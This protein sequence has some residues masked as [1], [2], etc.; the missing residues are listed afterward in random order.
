MEKAKPATATE[1]LYQSL[2]PFVG[3]EQYFLLYGKRG[4]VESQVIVP[5]EA[6]ESFLDEMEKLLLKEQAP[7]VMGSIKLFKGDRRLLRFEMD[8]VCIALD[9]ARCE[10]TMRFLSEMD[11]L[12]ISAGGIPFVIKDSRLPAET[13]KQC[14]PEYELMKQQL[15]HYDPKRLFRSEMSQ[16]LGL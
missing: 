9:L 3:K 4:L 8:G 11:R 12:T 5:H 13:V 16:R 10:K 6:S 15:M 2:F 14:Y 1:F 7:A